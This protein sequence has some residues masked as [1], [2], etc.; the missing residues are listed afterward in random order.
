MSEFVNKDRW[1]RATP[2]EIERLKSCNKIL[3]KQTK[4]IEGYIPPGPWPGKYGPYK[5]IKKGK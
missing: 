2:E 1:H 4:G 5:I 3:I